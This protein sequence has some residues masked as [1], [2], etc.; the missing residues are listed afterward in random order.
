MIS[1]NSDS[2]PETNDNLTHGQAAEN[3]A[4]RLAPPSAPARQRPRGQPIHLPRRTPLLPRRLATRHRRPFWQKGADLCASHGIATS[5]MV[6]LASLPHRNPPVA[7]RE[8]EIR[9]PIRQRQEADR[10]PPRPG[11]PPRRPTRP[12][13]PP[14]SAPRSRSPHRPHPERNPPPASPTRRVTSS[15]TASPSAAARK[16]SPT[17]S[18]STT[19]PATEP[20][21]PRNSNPIETS[22]P[23]SP[24]YHL[25]PHNN[26]TSR[27]PPTPRQIKNLSEKAGPAAWV[28]FPCPLSEDFPIAFLSLHPLLLTF[29]EYPFPAPL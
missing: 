24:M 7:P 11:P 17:A 3:P 29:P 15:T 9:P 26:G 16:H 14:R 6:R 5:R 20:C 22:S 28:A 21:S 8:Q 19:K 1:Q 2:F 18:T 10:P 13:N 12:R 27:P 25:R 4:T 23:P